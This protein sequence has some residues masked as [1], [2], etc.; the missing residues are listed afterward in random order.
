MEI[1]DGVGDGVFDHHA[2]DV[3]VDEPGGGLVHLVAQQQGRLFMAEFGDGDLAD[4]AGIVPDAH[5]AL[6]DAGL[7]VDAPDIGERDPAP[8]LRRL[9]E[10]GRDHSRRS[11]AQRQ[12]GDAHGVGPGQV[13]TGGQAA[14]GGEFGRQRPGP[15][16]PGL[17]ETQNLVVL[18]ALAQPGVGIGEDPGVG[19]AGEGRVAVP[20]PFE[21]VSEEYFAQATKVISSAISPAVPMARL[22][23]IEAGFMSKPLINM[24]SAFVSDATTV[25]PATLR[26][27]VESRCKVPF[28][29]PAANDCL[30]PKPAKAASQTCCP[31]STVSQCLAKLRVGLD[32]RESQI[33][34]FTTLAGGM[35]RFFSGGPRGRNCHVMPIRGIDVS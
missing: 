12:E 28:T 23:A 13:G 8:R 20:G 31:D 30:S 27:Q 16:P 15:R 32:G 19:I 7:A 3:A 10:Q 25:S 1:V 22:L 2:P 4:L 29:L 14:V 33:R 24:A 11:S 21:G 26:S 18:P 5:S 17:D 9:G 35:R 6:E 34:E